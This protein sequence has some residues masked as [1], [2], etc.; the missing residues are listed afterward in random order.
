MKLGEIVS[1]T[2]ET[3]ESKDKSGKTVPMRG[4]IVYIHPLRRFCTV[5]FSVGAFGAKIRE[6]FLLIEGVISE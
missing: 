1:V 5:A 4:E 6:S 2:P 3:L